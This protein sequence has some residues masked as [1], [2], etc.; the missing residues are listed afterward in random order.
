MVTAS[1]GNFS[2]NASNTLIRLVYETKSE[3]TLQEWLCYLEIKR[4][5]AEFI[6]SMFSVYSIQQSSILAVLGF[7]LNYIVILLQTENYGAQSQN[8][9]LAEANSTLQNNTLH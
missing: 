1:A 8:E 6:V 4:A 7:S 2:S 3:W 9:T 5:P